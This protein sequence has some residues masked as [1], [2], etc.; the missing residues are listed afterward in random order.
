MLYT[1]KGKIVFFGSDF[2]PTYIHFIESQMFKKIVYRFYKKFSGEIHINKKKMKILLKMHVTPKRIKIKYNL[3]KIKSD[4]IKSKILKT[5]KTKSN[6]HYS[7]FD[8]R[9]FHNFCIKKMNKN[10][11]LFSNN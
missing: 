2:S 9:D 7:I 6:F 5:K 4:L 8:V 3:N 10:S 1:N 11:F